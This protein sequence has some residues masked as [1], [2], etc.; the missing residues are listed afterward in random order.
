M[1]QHGLLLREI[2]VL[3]V[4]HLEALLHVLKC[5]DIIMSLLCVCVFFNPIYLILILQEIVHVLKVNS[6]VQA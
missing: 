5:T 2:V 3:Y 6:T 1:A 4:G